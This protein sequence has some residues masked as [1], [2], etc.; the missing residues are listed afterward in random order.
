MKQTEQKLQDFADGFS[1]FRLER[2][3]TIL[4]MEK[5]TRAKVCKVDADDMLLRRLEELGV[6]V[7]VEIEILD[8]LPFSGPVILRVSGTKMA[9]RQ[10][11]ARCIKVQI[12]NV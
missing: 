10:G 8:R 1:S 7:G 3:M 12:L 6:M 5:N 9:L 11:E 2:A 4:E